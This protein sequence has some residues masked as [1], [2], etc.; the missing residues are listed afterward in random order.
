[1]IGENRPI[2]SVDPA[3]KR[4]VRLVDGKVAIVDQSLQALGPLSASEVRKVSEIGSGGSMPVEPSVAGKIKPN[5]AEQCCKDVPVLHTPNEK[6][7]P[8]PPG[9]NARQT[10]ERNDGALG[11]QAASV[12]EWSSPTNV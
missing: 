8:Q 4:S 10:S 6:G 1:M 3:S 9:R 2:P 5:D 7:E 12:T 11:A